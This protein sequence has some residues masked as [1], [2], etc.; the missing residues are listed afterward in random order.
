NIIVQDS[1]LTGCDAPSLHT[2]YLDKWMNGHTLMQAIARVNRVHPGKEGGLIVDYMDMSK[3]I[4][5]A[6]SD[7]TNGGGHGKPANEQDEAVGIMLEK[8][9]VVKSMFHGFDYMKFFNLKPEE[10]VP[11]MS[12]AVDH[13]L[14]EPDV[15]DRFLK[16]FTALRGAFSIALPRE[17]AMKIK[18]DV[19]FFEA[20]K[21]AITKTTRSD[22]PDFYKYEA[23]I[24]QIIS[25]AIVSDDIIDIIGNAGNLGTE[26]SILSEVFLS[27]IKKSPQKHLAREALLRILSDKIR[28][29]SKRN[30]VKGKSFRE[31][32]EK[33][34][35]RYN[36]KIINTH[37]VIDELI[38]IAKQ[39]RNEKDR[40]K[41]LDLDEDEL[42]FYDALEVNDSAVN[43]LGNKALKTIAE[44][45]TEMIRKNV[46]IDWA[47]KDS[48]RA[49]IRLKVKSI[50]KRYGYPPDKTK[51]ATNTVLSQ[52]EV[53]AKNWTG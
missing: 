44:E 14:R 50:L 5:D 49:E 9:D 3:E 47:Q 18:N 41:T 38:K 8:Y 32:L 2:M 25:K 53:I 36:D 12:R 26:V 46:T 6:I 52:A 40:G 27:N 34:I 28:V 42:A 13:I 19:G 37:E 29:Y 43:V 21:A 51:K 10:R 11:F 17:E 31:L 4:R 35:S 20:I 23:G 24:K 1:F 48:V 33:T 39:I 7:Y 15:K 22:G 45:L 16:A 30:M